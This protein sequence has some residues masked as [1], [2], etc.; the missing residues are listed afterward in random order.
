MAGRQGNRLKSF[1]KENFELMALGGGICFILNLFFTGMYLDKYFGPNFQPTHLALLFIVVAIG[2]LN[3]HYL[4]KS[5][6]STREDALASFLVGIFTAISFLV[7]IF[8]ILSIANFVGW[9]PETQLS[10]HILILIFAG[11]TLF[12][13]QASELTED[14]EEIGKLLW[15]VFG[16]IPFILLVLWILFEYVIPKAEQAL[17][18]FPL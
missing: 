14:E 5:L 6:D 18:V 8:T 15:V 9:F 17:P 16:V 13:I 10:S 11:A 12:L 1:L 2:S 7:V 3:G 4:G